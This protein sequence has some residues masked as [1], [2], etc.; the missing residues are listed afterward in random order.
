MDDG[1]RFRAHAR[2][3]RAIAVAA[4]NSGERRRLAQMAAM[5]DRFAEEC[6][7]RAGKR[8]V[9]PPPAASSHQTNR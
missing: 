8:D 5:W 9:E 2:R 4:R 7:R 3:C 6:D 1:E